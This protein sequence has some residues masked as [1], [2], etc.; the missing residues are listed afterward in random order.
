M[1]RYVARAARYT[2]GIGEP[3]IALVNGIEMETGK[4]RI[5][6]FQ[7]GALLDHE[8]E[9]GLKAFTFKGLADG[10]TPE[11]RLSVFDTRDYQKAHKLTDEER[12]E[13]ERTLESSGAF[14]ADFI[15]VEEIHAAKP[16]PSYDEKSPEEI[17]EIV[18]AAEIDPNVAYRYEAENQAREELLDAY[19]KLG[20]DPVGVPRE[21]ESL[22][23][24][25][26]E[27]IFKPTG[28]LIV[29]A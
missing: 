10:V 8:I 5:A 3:T 4:K 14:G 15:K 25:E 27:S 21:L 24:N 28:E 7:A 26:G 1:A 22:S 11:T 2:H 19:V 20:A 16:F 23:L 18:G 17:L 13:I 29:R 12:E 9:A 6:K